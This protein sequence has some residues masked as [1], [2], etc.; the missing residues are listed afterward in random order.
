MR[1]K[2]ALRFCAREAPR[3]QSKK[4]IRAAPEFVPALG[5]SSWQS[6]TPTAV[7]ALSGGEA[8]AIAFGVER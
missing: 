4:N 3:D 7:L 2:L 1:L 8:Q 6:L 5:Y